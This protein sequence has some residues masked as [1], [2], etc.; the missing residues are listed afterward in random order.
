MDNL[1]A[2]RD[3]DQIETSFLCSF[4]Q[5]SME[6]SSSC[7]PQCLQGDNDPSLLGFAALTL[8]E[9]CHI[10]NNAYHLHM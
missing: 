9:R 8:L 1:E 6:S 2:R 5:L 10:L 7:F 4:F 3:G